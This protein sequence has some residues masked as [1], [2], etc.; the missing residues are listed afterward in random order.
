MAGLISSQYIP[1]FLEK[2]IIIGD[3]SEVQLSD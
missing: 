2:P 3:L 1:G